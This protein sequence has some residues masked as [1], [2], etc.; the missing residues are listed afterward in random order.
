[1][2]FGHLPVTCFPLPGDPAPPCMPLVL[3]LNRESTLLQLRHSVN[4]DDMYN[5]YWYMSGVNQSMKDALKSIVDEALKRQP[6]TDGSLV[7]D[8]AAN[9]GML[10]GAYPSSLF[11]V[12]IDPAKNIQCKNCNVHINTFFSK[13]VYEQ[14]LGNKK[15]E[16]VT[17]VAMFY[18]LEDPIQFARDVN[19]IL[20]PNGLWILELNYLPIILQ[21]NAFDSISSEHL[22]YYTLRTVEY[23]LDRSGFE[24]ED[25]VLNDVN[26]GSFRLYIRKEGFAQPTMSVYMM[27][28]AERTM[29]LDDPE[30]YRNFGKR[31]EENKKETI[32]FL[33]TQRDLGKKVFGYG[34]STRGNTIM[35]YFGIGPDLVPYIAERNPLKFGRTTPTGI[36]IISEEEARSKHPDYLLAFPYHFMNEFLTRETAFLKRGG[37]FLSP[38]PRLTVIPKVRTNVMS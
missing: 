30:T 13:E 5:E 34:A 37:K 20:K 7:V 14:H 23:I 15:A 21:R 35:G 24:V 3:A 36:P 33:K 28:E 8:I 31:V 4:P 16:V 29:N 38:V 1:M 17:S 12:G 32:D 27:R 10:L 9:D 11:R 6:L 19:E 26:G 22:E 25:L 18:D 2:D